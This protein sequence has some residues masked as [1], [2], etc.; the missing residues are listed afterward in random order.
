MPEQYFFEGKERFQWVFDS[1]NYCGALLGVFCLLVA[2]AHVWLSIRGS[3]PLVR[4]ICLGGFVLGAVL[5]GL[6]YSR[7]A[8]VGTCVGFALPIVASRNRRRFGALLVLF[9]IIL[10]LIPQGGARI[11]SVASMEDKSNLHRIYVWEGALA[12]YADYWLWGAGE[13]EFGSMYGQWYQDLDKNERYNAALNNWLTIASERGI[14]IFFL[15]LLLSVFPLVALV[16]LLRA[17]ENSPMWGSAAA[18]LSVN[19]SGLFSFTLVFQG[20]VISAVALYSVVVIYLIYRWRY[21]FGSAA[22]MLAGTSG[23]AAFIAIAGLFVG[24]SLSATREVQGGDFSCGDGSGEAIVARPRKGAQLGVIVYLP[25]RD[26][27]RYTVIRNVMRPLAAMGYKVISFPYRG[28]GRSALA[29]ASSDLR[30]L[31]QNVDYV[32]GQNDAGRQAILLSLRPGHQ[33]F[34]IVA[35]RPELTWPFE[36]LSPMQQIH[37]SSTAIWLVLTDLNKE[38]REFLAE[39]IRTGRRVRLLPLADE[40]DKAEWTNLFLTMRHTEEHD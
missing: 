17:T 18:L 7:G 3:L 16:Y 4:S 28:A 25:Y 26:E 20:L 22:A 21:W 1:P 30:V 12:M 40:I 31:G 37:R 9:L 35:I 23:F 19:I 39:A 34:A 5:L 14:V 2:G 29:A 32:I 13:G 11:R 8:W 27:S 6:T 38:S 24:F 33:N 10:L 36:D 15:F